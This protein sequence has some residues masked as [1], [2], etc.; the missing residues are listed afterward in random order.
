MRILLLFILF[1]LNSFSQG[2]SYD[3]AI[4]QLKNY[5][6]DR[7]EDILKEVPPGEKDQL[8]IALLD[9]QIT[10]LKSGMKID[11]DTTVIPRDISERA[12]TLFFLKRGEQYLNLQVPKDSLG[13]VNYE[14]AL[15]NAIKEKDTLFVCE[16]LKKIIFNFY[17]NRQTHQLLPKYLTLYKDYAYDDSEIALLSYY[18]IALKLRKERKESIPEFKKV[19]DKISGKNNYIEVKLLQII[20]NSYSAYL[21]DTDSG[22]AYNKRAEKI[23]LDIP[24]VYAKNELFGIWTNIATGYRKKGMFKEA[25][26][27]YQKVKKFALPKNRYL[28]YKKL[29]RLMAI[30]FD[31]LKM[32]DSIS[33]YWELRSKYSDSL[34]AVEEL[35]AVTEIKEKYKA[36]EKEKENLQ[37]QQ[38]ILISNN[39]KNIAFGIAG[40]LVLTVISGVFILKNTRKKKLIAEQ[41]SLIKTKEVET[42]LKEQELQQIDA[43]IVG[44]E[45]ERQRIANDLH[46]NLG[47]DLATLKL[48]FHHL[49]EQLKKTKTEEE[50]FEKTDQLIAD[51]YQKTRNIAHAKNSGVI[52]NQGLLPAIQKMAKKISLANK[53]EVTVH[54]ANLTQRLEN[55]LEIT[56]FRIV[57]ELVTNCIKH[58]SASQIT[59]YL[60]EHE[61]SLNVMVEDNGGGFNTRKIKK[62]DGMGLYSIEKRIE[63]LGG[64]MTV[65]SQKSKG[66]TVILDIPI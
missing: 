51:A 61:E 3:K 17:K 53:I 30:N 54:E 20:G 56:I 7:A 26:E 39:S 37:L 19:L 47:G 23:L 58:A 27:Y 42:I 48:H 43:M 1:S 36:A 11:I 50:L 35:V 46:D 52:A 12:K 9:W 22:I 44:Q 8:L 62:Q 65:E 66:T 6:L 13:F 41:Q 32:S 59:I 2:N 4:L 33:Y 57:Q 40:I 14:M 15:N 21:R 49:K 5:N 31:S 24:Y 16:A 45:K 29:Y 38:D 63:H 10:A 60:T 34:A 28:E 64:T 18:Q 25:N 55:T